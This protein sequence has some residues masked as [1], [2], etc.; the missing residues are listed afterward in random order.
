M[1][2]RLVGF[3]SAIGIAM[4]MNSVGVIGQAAADT[5]QKHIAAAKA[6]AGQEYAWIYNTLCVEALGNMGKPPAPPAAPSAGRSS[7]PPA[8]STWHAEP[9][10]VFDNLYRVGTIEHSAW[11]VTTSGGII[12]MDAIFSYNVQD[13]VVDGLRKLGLD[14]GTIKYAI[15]AHGHSD[16]VG[17][18]KALQ[19]LFGTHV[20]LAAPDWDLLE[21]T[22]PGASSAAGGPLPKRDMVGTDGMKVTLGDTTITTYTTPGHTQGTLSS[23]IPLKD[24]G[25]PHVAAYWGGT[26]FNW[27]ANRAQYITPK[28]PDKYWFDTYAASADKFRDI[29]AKAGADVILSNHTD[30]DNTKIKEPQLKLRKPGDPFH[31]Y[32]VGKDSV[33]HYLTTVS[34]CAKAGSLMSK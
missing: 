14:P 26:M 4:A 12:L 33:Q 16:H 20:I 19:E 24:G 11:A 27:I 7:G 5:P 8:R 25:K 18:A 28:T 9:A 10:K 31:P 21:R 15:I 22:G 32:V 1:S 6:A 23:I 29:A 30:Y 2:V 34:E 13:E 3:L 17:G